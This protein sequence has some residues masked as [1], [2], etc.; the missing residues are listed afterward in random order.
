MNAKI[1][2]TCFILLFLFL[3]TAVSAADV[4]N[5]TIL[6]AQQPDSNQEL[7]KLSTSKTTVKEKVTLSAPDLKMY[8]KD[9][10]K[11]KA[12]VKNKNKKAITKAK[13]DFTVNGKV[14]SKQ[15][16]SKGN[17]Y[18]TIS[19]K[20]GNY[21]ITTKFAGTSKYSASSKKS[22]ITVKSTIK[23]SDFK[24][25]YKNTSPYT[26]TFY[27][28]KGSILKNTAVK[29]KL[30][31]KYY[32]VKTN[33]KGIGKLSVNTKPG[34]YSI[35]I[36]NPKT[37]E[38]ISKKITIKS[39]IETTDLTINN[40]NDGKFNVKVFNINGNIYPNQKVTF[41]LNG[42]TYSK[43]TNKN[44]IA[45]LDINLDAEKYSITTEYL[46]LKNTNKININ[47]IVKSA[48]YTHTTL[49]PNYV[50][51]TAKLVINNSVYCL[52]SGINGI[53]KMPKKELFKIQIGDK[54]YIFST[55]SNS[56]INSTQLRY[57]YSYLVPFDGSGIKIDENKKNLT[58]AGIILT[59]VDDYTQIDYQSKT[60]D[61][62]AL[63]GFYASKGLDKSETLTYME[64]DKITA[65]VNFQTLSFDEFGVMYSLSAL[66]GKTIYNFNYENYDDSIRFTNTNTPVTFSYFG[67]SIVGYTSKEDIITKFRIDD[68]EEYEKKE[69]IS[70]GLNNNYRTAM[71]FEV[72]QSY[73][74]INEKITQNILENW[75]S[76][77]P[78]Y[79][80]RFGVMNVYGMHLASLEVTWLADILADSNSKELNVNWKR[81]KSLT[82]LGGINLDDTYL[83]IL[84]ADMGMEVTGDSNN[85]FLFRLLNSV[86]LPNIE[87]YALLKV[88]DRY[89]DKSSNSLDNVFS[90]ILENTFSIAQ[91]GD[92]IYIFSNNTNS[93]VI[94]NITSGVSSVILAQNSIYKG[95][96][97]KT[98]CDCCGVGILPKDII[99]GIDDTINFIKN[100][101]ETIYENKTHPFTKLLYMTA[102]LLAKPLSGLGS[103]GMNIFTT[104]ALIQSG[105]V[106][107]RNEM[108]EKTEWH[109]V[110]DKITFTR[111]GYLQSKKIYN[112]PNENG[113]YDFIE[114]KIKDDMT[115][116]RN[117]AVY[118]S[119]GKTRKLSEEET[120]EYFSDKYWS[121]FNI[122][123]KY[124]DESWNR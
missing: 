80:S 42:K 34:T 103:L 61:N 11:F 5:E 58:S 57:G 49:I 62:I 53:I 27:D 60:K 6:T 19:L 25:Y 78:D 93:S 82:I 81:S 113:D 28:K 91:L 104:M 7:N 16:D 4:K 20:S 106:T 45:I 31:S 83:N 12:T 24:K 23:C 44:G 116:D 79:L 29:F 15:T 90:S 64:N 17:V 30:N 92:L 77:N 110:M 100:G 51:V 66:H 95:S 14:Y 71:G 75:V 38:T 9:G 97:I 94:I 67:N 88:A 105:G 124:W 101:L 50:N 37:S 109:N 115:L 112:I 33:S 22:T 1:N 86:N 70:Y 96:S 3:I 122:P 114:V 39:L 99:K 26:S 32:S 123:Q 76:R 59:K 74:I 35:T 36:T 84:N 52:K 10:S 120:Y 54:V 2:T 73:T 87:E 121:P 8:Y 40:R 41:K 89:L 13:V 102:N 47:K 48:S 118:I 63:F 69:S 117:N 111:P 107:Y 18:L 65:K 72:L 85:T 46:D 98:T 21:P 43:T 119:D 56:G 68:T 55:S 108:V